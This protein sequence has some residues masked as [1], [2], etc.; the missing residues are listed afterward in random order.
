MI[1]LFLAAF[2]L[3]IQ[4]ASAIEIRVPESWSQGEVPPSEVPY[5]MPPAIR[6]MIR[7]IPPTKDGTASISEMKPLISLDEAAKTYIRAMSVRGITVDSTSNVSQ[8][9]H[10]GRRIKGHMS[11]ADR[12]ITF[13]VEAFILETEDCILS[14]EVISK[15]ASSMLNE[16]LS[17]ID[18]QADAVPAK[19]RDT[20]GTARRSFWEYVGFGVVLMAVGYAIFNSKFT[21]N[22]RSD[23]NKGCCEVA[24][25]AETSSAPFS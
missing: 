11:F 10:E 1:R 5:Q 24:A 25:I 9:G 7:L 4:C 12:D 8:N 23:N 18:F 14:V 13:P 19:A 3:I 16:I 6:P 22:K 2:F 21:R 17:W 20:S 15:S